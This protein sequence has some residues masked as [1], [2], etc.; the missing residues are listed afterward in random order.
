M[1]TAALAAGHAP[2]ITGWPEAADA[3]QSKRFFAAYERLKERLNASRP[4]LLIVITPEHW[5]NF[6][7]DKMPPFC[8][9]IGEEFEGPLE[10]PAFLRIPKTK[11]RGAPA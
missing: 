4:E 1:I 9:G 3:E 2:G 5:A 11:V 7:L 8:L 10:D 6:F